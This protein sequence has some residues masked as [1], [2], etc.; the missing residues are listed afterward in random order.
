MPSVKEGQSKSEYISYCISWIKE[1]EPEKAEWSSG[2]LYKHCEGLWDNRNKTHA[3]TMQDISKELDNIGY[4]QI[5]FTSDGIGIGK[6]EGG[7]IS[8]SDMQ[9]EFESDGKNVRR[10]DVVDAVV[11]VGDRFYGN[12]YVPSSVLKASAHQWNST[13]N[14]ISHLGTMY[15]A[16]MGSVENME[17]ITGYNSD[18]NFD[19][20][21]N[22]VR[23]K[24][25]INQNAPKYGVWKSYMDITKDAKRI[26][27]V[28]IFGFYKSKAIRK[29]QIPSGTVIPKTAL[30]G[31]YI[32]AMA[33][34]IPFA[35]T[36]CLKGKCDDVAG[37]GISTGF[38]E[39]GAQCDCTSGVCIPPEK[40]DTKIIVNVEVDL[41]KINRLQDRIKELKE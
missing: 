12:M 11:A 37:C 9:E 31:D 2:R 40:E 38:T 16:G 34:L 30:H 39:D 28:S 33:D 29:S 27:N 15:P 8:M 41:E 14:D 7:T 23:V 25:H 20:A 21:I 4:R 22:A 35:I 3:S 10:Y 17:Y 26:P 24:M 6:L 1:H 5:A 18:A 13:Y 36:T 19:E 32:I